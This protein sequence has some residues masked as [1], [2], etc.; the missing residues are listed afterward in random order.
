MTEAERHA[1]ITEAVSQIGK[2]I[3]VCA[4]NGLDKSD[5]LTMMQTAT[6]LMC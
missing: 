3:G 5:I 1:K 6:S 2:L 4:Q